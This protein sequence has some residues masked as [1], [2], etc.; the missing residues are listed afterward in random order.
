MHSSGQTDCLHV[1]TLSGSQATMESRIDSKSKP[2]GLLIFW[3]QSV[4]IYLMICKSIKDST[5][6]K[7]STLNLVLSKSS[8][9]KRSRVSPIPELVL[10]Y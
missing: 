5:A 8:V 4:V 7:L 10:I 6:S 1:L 2:Q 9:E 3:R